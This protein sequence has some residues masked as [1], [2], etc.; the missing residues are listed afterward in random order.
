MG[1]EL[2][3]L[4]QVLFELADGLFWGYGLFRRLHGVEFLHH[5]DPDVSSADHRKELCMGRKYTA[6]GVNRGGKAGIMKK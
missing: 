5:L 2:P 4:V 1:E 3:G 6:K